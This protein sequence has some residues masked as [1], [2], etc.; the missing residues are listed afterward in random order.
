MNSESFLSHSNFLEDDIES[1]NFDFR[2][3][4]PWYAPPEESQ[5]KPENEQT[6]SE[7]EDKDKDK[8]GPSINPIQDSNSTDHTNGKKKINRKR[9]KP[10][11]RLSSDNV[12]RKIQVHYFSF[13]VSFLNFLLKYFNYEYKFLKLDYSIKKNIN[14]DVNKRKS[15]IGNEN[16]KII[17]SFDDDTIEKIISQNISKQFRHYKKNQNELICEAVKE[18]KI[19]CNILKENHLNIFKKFYFSS[20]KLINLKEYGLDRCIKLPNEVKTH[21]DLLKKNETFG[22][23]YKKCIN[24]CILKNFFPK[25]KFLF[26]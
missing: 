16:K 22:E 3:I 19:F 1:Q 4:F 18:N 5:F 6:K 14:K 11:N 17:N 25:A 12:L 9:K 7:H 8:E 10:H 15:K 24:E 21:I 23:E 2:S 20:S 26:Y 13:I